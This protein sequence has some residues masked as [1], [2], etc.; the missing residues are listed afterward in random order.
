[1]IAAHAGCRLDAGMIF[2]YISEPLP[3]FAM[4]ASHDNG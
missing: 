3:M 2:S 1:M 4:T